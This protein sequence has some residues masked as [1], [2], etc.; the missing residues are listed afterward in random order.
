M[1][2]RLRNMTRADIP[3][4]ARLER[5]LHGRSAW[6]SLAFHEALDA[7]PET[8]E[9]V[10]IDDVADESVRRGA[11]IAYGIVS[12]AG[13]ADD[14]EAE[15]HDLG[16]AVEHQ[17][18]GLGRRM[19]TELIERARRREAREVFLDVRVGNEPALALY[20][21]FGFTEIGQRAGYYGA[22]VDAAVLRRSL[23]AQAMSEPR[24][25]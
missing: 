7:T 11:P 19:L 18:R 1:T 9:C 2:Y 4:I 6:S 8:Y 25:G 3:R 20:R 5:V 22:G 14:R 15:V 10:V 21:A 24:H 23:T 13:P 12:I 17:R 16:V